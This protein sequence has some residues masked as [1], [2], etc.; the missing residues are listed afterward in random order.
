LKF[1]AALTV[2]YAALG[3][4]LAVISEVTIQSLPTGL[5][6]LGLTLAPVAALWS[7]YLIALRIFRLESRRTVE[8]V[9]EGLRETRDGRELKFMPWAGVKEVELDATIGA[10]ATLRVKGA[11][12]EIV[13]SNIDLVIDAPMTIRDMHR[14]MGGM[15]R[16]RTVF[17]RLKASAPAAEFKMN[18]LARRRLDGPQTERQ[19]DRNA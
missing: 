14:A 6:I 19:L 11:F 13:I 7:V 18:D 1:V 3:V 10:G 16:M 17:A 5:L 8:L 4:G 9:A 2:L 15:G 12:T